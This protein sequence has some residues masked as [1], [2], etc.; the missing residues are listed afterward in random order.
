MGH[1]WFMGMQVL[2]STFWSCRTW[3]R[4][5]EERKARLCHH[6]AT[7]KLLPHRGS[8]PAN[9]PFPAHGTSCS[10]RSPGLLLPTRAQNGQKN[11]PTKTKKNRAK[12]ASLRIASR[13]LRSPGGAERSQHAAL[14]ERPP[15]DVLAAQAD[16]DALFE[17]GAERHVLCQGPVHSPVLHHLPAGFQNTAQTCGDTRCRRALG[18]KAPVPQPARGLGNCKRLG[19]RTCLCW[20]EAQGRGSRT[21]GKDQLRGGAAPRSLNHSSLVN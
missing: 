9:F 18:D 13:R 19:W 11:P 7:H 10:M 15:L 14:P 5:L 6:P 3:W 16:V 21:A 8:M 1:R 4:W 17:E 12:T 2:L 20:R